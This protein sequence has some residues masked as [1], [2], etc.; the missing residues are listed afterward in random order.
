MRARR[1]VH[2]P[3]SPLRGGLV[4]I[5]PPTDT[6]G[7]TPRAKQAVLDWPTVHCGCAAG[8]AA[9]L[10]CTTIRIHY[11]HRGGVDGAACPPGPRVASSLPRR[12]SCSK[13]QYP[14]SLG[15]STAWVALAQGARRRS[16]KASHIYNRVPEGSFRVVERAAHVRSEPARRFGRVMRKSLSC[17]GILCACR[18]AHGGRNCEHDPS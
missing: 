17:S 6:E 11:H 10:R 16:V 14:H 2:R 15:S 5:I 9:S 3:P 7:G 1:A 13:R 4:P 18:V 8:L 12:G